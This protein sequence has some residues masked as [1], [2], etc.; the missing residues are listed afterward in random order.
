[1]IALCLVALGGFLA[2]RAVHATPFTVEDFG[3]SVGLGTAD[4]K[5]TIINIIKWVLGILALTAL[6]FIIYGG[7][8]WLTSAGNPEKIQKAKRIILNAVIGMV[9]V[10]ISW[11]IVL[12]VTRVITGATS[13]GGGP[14]P[15]CPP[16]S[17]LCTPP[18]PIG[19]EIRSI[20]TDCENADIGDYRH[21]V[22]ICS[23]V[24]VTFNHVLNGETVKDAVER[25]KPG[26]AGMPKLIIEQ[27]TDGVGGTEACTSVAVNPDSALDGHP[28]DPDDNQL[29]VDGASATY[30]TDIR[31]G[32]AWTARLDNTGKSIAFFHH[33]AY[34][35][36]N[37]WFR[38][39]IPKSIEDLKGNQIS[40]CRESATK[41]VDGCDD[42]RIPD[43]WT[44]TMLTGDKVDTES[45]VVT[46]SYPDSRYLTKPA[47]RPDRNVP[48]APMI[49]VHYNKAI[50]APAAGDVVIE[51]FDNAD[52]P[53][54][55]TGVGGTI[56]G[57]VPSADYNVLSGIDGK[58]VTI[59][60]KNPKLLQKF[61]WYRVTI[62]NVIDMC[63]NPQ[64]PE[65]F[66]WVFE[67]ND[68][69]PGVAQ[70]YPPNGYDKS[71]PATPMFIQ[72]TI[73]MYDP[74]TSSC[75]V[76]PAGAGG[77]YVL[78]PFDLQPFANK[79]FVVDDDCVDGCTMPYNRCKVYSFT[80]PP[81]G[82]PLQPNK[83]YEVAVQNSY[84]INDKGE[85]L[86]YGT[87]NSPGWP[88]SG[89]A[90]LGG[91]TFQTKEPGKCADPP[92]ITSIDPPQGTDGQCVTIHGYNFD[93]NK[94]GALRDGTGSPGDVDNVLYG[95]K[96]MPDSTLGKWTDTQIGAT[97]LDDVDDPPGARPKNIP[98]KIQTKYPDP[99]GTLE[100]VTPYNWTKVAGDPSD[101]PCLLSLDPDTG[102][103]GSEFSAGGKRFNP[104]S[105]TKRVHFDALLLSYLTWNDARITGLTVP[106]VPVGASYSVS[107]E[108]SKGVSNEMLFTVAPTPPGQP[109]V[110]DRWPACATSCLGADIGAE[111]N[112]D[113]D[114]ATLTTSSVK[115]LKCTD[116][117]CNAFVGGELAITVTPD[118]SPAAT[119]VRVIP[120][121]ALAA[122]SWY[123]AV[124]LNSIKGA[125]TP[126]DGLLGG[127][128]FRYP[129]G[130]GDANAYSW[131]FRTAAPGAEGCKLDRVE[132]I[133]K[134]YE[135]HVK[136]E[137]KLYTAESYT[138]P[139]ACSAGGQRITTSSAW[140]WSSPDGTS[141][142]RAAGTQYFDFVP[143]ATAWTVTVQAK[144]QSIPDST[145]VVATATKAG[146]SKDGTGI[147]MIN[148]DYCTDDAS[149]QKDACTGSVCDL[150]KHTCTPFVKSITPKHGDIGT[151]M[152][153]EGC[154]FGKYVKGTCANSG[155]DGVPCDTVND[156]ADATHLTP[157]CVGGSN[158]LYNPSGSR[159][160]WPDPARCGSIN[161]TETSITSEVPNPSSVVDPGWG[162][163]TAGLNTVKVMRWDGKSAD[164]SDQFD[165]DG[166][167]MPGICRVNPAR[168]ST[169][170]TVTLTGQ[171]FGAA[172]GGS[173]VVF[174]DNKPVSVYKAW[175]D[176]DVTVVAPVDIANN[177]V[178]NYEY[179]VGSGIFWGIG[180]GRKEIIANVISTSSEWSN[181]KNFEVL[182]PGCAA[183]TVD[184]DCTL[185]NACGYGGCC[186]KIPSIVSKAPDDGDVDVCRNAVVNVEFDISMDPKTMTSAA[187]HLVKNTG[188]G[189]S[190]VAS[191][192][193]YD[194]E[195]KSMTIAPNTLLDRL[196]NYS[197]ILGVQAS[198]LKNGGFENWSG[199]N[200]VDWTGSSP[201]IT[202]SAEIPPGA[203]P[204]T[205]SAHVDAS[206]TTQLNLL[207]AASSSSPQKRSFR[208][209]GWVRYHN[210][211]AAFATVGGLITQCWSSD[212]VI[213]AD[214]WKYCPQGKESEH[215][216]QYSKAQGLF[217][218]AVG[219][220]SG[221]KY[222]D[223]VVSN[224]TGYNLGLQILC[225]AT[226]GIE[227]W[228][229]DVTVTEV[230]PT[231]IRSK[232]GAALPTTSWS[233]TTADTD[234]PCEVSK[235]RVVPSQWTFTTSDP[236]KPESHKEFKM[237]AY[238]DKDVLLKQT[239]DVFE[240]R[241]TWSR[242]SVPPGTTPPVDFDP[243]P[244][245]PPGA[246]TV[247]VM[248]VPIKGKARLFG[249]VQASGKCVS[250]PT[251]GKYCV[252]SGVCGGG[253]CKRPIGQTKTV[254]GSALINNMACNNPW[255]PD[256]ANYGF[257]DSNNGPGTGLY[258]RCT[259]E[260][261]TAVCQDY[262]FN[263]GY[264]RDGQ[265]SK[266]VV[267]GGAG[268]CSGGA[269][270]G[271]WCVLDSMCPQYPYLSA[272]AVTQYE[273]AAV[274]SKPVLLKE[275]LFKEMDPLTGVFSPDSKDAIGIRIYD[276]VEGLSALEW[277]KKY[278]PNPRATTPL[279]VDGYD[280]IRDG[281]TVYVG[282]SNLD[283]GIF[284]SKIFLIS[285]NV[286]A[287]KNMVDIYNQ[288]LES[289]FF[290]NNP[291]LT[292]VCNTDIPED[293]WE[294][295]KA[296]AQ[297]D[298]RRIAG[299]SDVKQYLMNY[300]AAN[301]SYPK[302]D[303][304]SY[305]P[306]LS[307]S[308]WPS[309]QSTLGGDVKQSLPVDPKNTVAN[310]PADYSKDGAC[311]SEPKKSFMCTNAIGSESYVYGYTSRTCYGGTDNGKACT[312][313]LDCNGGICSA[314]SGKFC[315]VS[316]GPCI[317]DSSCT[318]GG[319]TCS[320]TVARARLYANLEYN[321]PGS[322]INGA[323][324]LA[325]L[326]P[327]GST[328]SCF[329][330]HYDIP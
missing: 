320:T 57:T 88:W 313:A 45:P 282:G 312:T 144:N 125:T 321:G 330:Y 319:D 93:G 86:N 43:T 270:A 267:S 36:K 325:T 96:V 136:D 273:T 39:T 231:F 228:C 292:P 263:I 306:N 194:D 81:T 195:I 59:S 218:G 76:L 296:C 25:T 196:T 49:S 152:G 172:Q 262:H 266:C 38:V 229:D 141:P 216:D 327:A 71:C 111:F 129:V 297:R 138:E 48:T 158:I 5:T 254:S 69:V 215:F 326:C 85:T 311:W 10:L 107:V 202:Q 264:C 66:V 14:P 112:K 288:L 55:A 84:I 21:G 188:T 226:D 233:F 121:A 44:W 285:Y 87:S 211:S 210:V 237:Y 302:L 240:W 220:D 291:E 151:W 117:K 299:L 248:S 206:T 239:T 159:G 278:A 208:V 180:D 199:G 201:S 146:V 184:T 132:V 308:V 160:T 234:G 17:P 203:T 244:A 272:A 256:G 162:D 161:W 62:S 118:S 271:Q 221:W 212:P 33:P 166:V 243:L 280:A 105:P 150:T 51:S 207:Q 174:Y 91:W 80:R 191:K 135:M 83:S 143:A 284:S 115:F 110:I 149:C 99:I 175:S 283:A 177:I 92:V 42:L 147:L 179:P 214:P 27:C 106:S 281:T 31:K 145:S 181:V 126:D 11:A 74:A 1:M 192:I 47:F 98:M 123:R 154:H 286:G 227:V 34:Y 70:V 50:F 329:N 230:T 305:L 290:N 190:E 178:D 52:P 13:G 97:M 137:T 26:Q 236:T 120:T 131:T 153:I 89:D 54:P 82:D 164:A 275:F 304:G 209:T 315:S 94:D 41:P 139:N 269:R 65:P 225:F 276:N 103:V 279:S 77:G 250:G 197:V 24:N 78:F 249:Y 193:T 102:I 140:N 119:K 222:I 183:C 238:S 219:Y 261:G 114:A 189:T 242:Q 257:T 90:K 9:I 185:G 309:W 37:T 6:V 223:F 294:P 156:C 224:K 108:N 56:N 60:M 16:G 75:K 235:V 252:T 323:S 322:W 245:A 307:F 35:D 232:E 169:G 29:F 8:I 204:G 101:G 328:C 72:Y 28:G 293:Q 130:A 79:Q 251:P 247:T 314:G 19:L 30:S 317:D 287:S 142:P 277:Y 163:V 68:T 148:F 168:G 73:S 205:S 303:A 122:G 53:D 301:K 268:K 260:R 104:A 259:I 23:G 12:F 63:S 310:C 133:P 253:T 116:D 2:M 165:M 274:S 246:D 186:A 255:M 128:N 167:K 318:G 182:P 124:L 176:T 100:S 300:Y 18:P 258:N 4:L 265:L 22:Y 173:K 187:A 95:A 127:L 3:G 324:D 113:V 7:V 217:S 241:W 32:A 64:K 61:T 316:G 155:K 213:A 134:T 58:S 200:A 170:A 15:K 20:T 109:I 289:W 157:I 298:L 171:N 40:A 67:T 295:L 198:T 46:S